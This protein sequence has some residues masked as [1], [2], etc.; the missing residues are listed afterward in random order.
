MNPIGLN[1]WNYV[2]HIDEKSLGLPTHVAELGYTAVEIPMTSP[3]LPPQLIDE[4]RATNLAVTCCVAMFKG[5]DISNF[6]PAIRTNTEA[7]LTQCLESASALGATTLVGPMYAGGGKAH[8]L[9]DDDRKREWELAVLGLRN[10]AQR[11]RDLGVDLAIEPI[12]RYRTSVVNTVAQGLQMVADIGCANV[13]LHFDTYQAGIEEESIVLALEQ[14]LQAKQ[15]F[16]FH[17]CANNRMPPPRGH[18]PWDEIFKTLRRAGYDRHVTVETFVY[19]GLDSGYVLAD[20]TPDQIATSAL[21]Y[22][23]SAVNGMQ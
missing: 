19:G 11:G 13:G 9:S 20:Q 14:V 15:L 1:L 5:R 3:V 23:K 12:N 18:F 4:V 7:Y 2:T 17:A 21:T 8:F 10:M 16:H 6:D 22:L